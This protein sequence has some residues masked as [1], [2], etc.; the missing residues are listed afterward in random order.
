LDRKVQACREAVIKRH[1]KQRACSKTMLE[2]KMEKWLRSRG[3]TLLK[4]EEP[5]EL[6]R[7]APAN[8]KFIAT[9]KAQCNYPGIV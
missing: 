4:E 3:V 1:A 7:Q 2:G 9:I 5:D 6:D 8:G